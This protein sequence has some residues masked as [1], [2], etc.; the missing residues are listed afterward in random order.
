MIIILKLKMLE[1]LL[2]KGIKLNL[3]LNSKEEKCNIQTLV[4]I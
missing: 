4:K 3:L 1:N 2:L